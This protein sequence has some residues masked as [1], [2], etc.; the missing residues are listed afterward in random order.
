[1]LDLKTKQLITR[2][3][4]IGSSKWSLQ[5]AK[6]SALTDEVKSARVKG[7]YKS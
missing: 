1:M 5:L 2:L 4:L 3:Q 6:G 7:K